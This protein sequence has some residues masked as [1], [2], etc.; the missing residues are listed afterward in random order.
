MGALF[1]W[2]C[3]QEHRLRDPE[4]TPMCYCF[5]SGGVSKAASVWSIS[6]QIGCLCP[7]G[8]FGIFLA[9]L[10]T[11]ILLNIVVSGL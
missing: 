11:E 2:D 8:I 4:V 7:T 9:Y 6:H 1:F 10:E 3:Q 5:S